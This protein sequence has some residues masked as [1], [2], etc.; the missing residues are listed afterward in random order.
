[1][2]PWIFAQ[3]VLPWEAVVFTQ[4]GGCVGD[5]QSWVQSSGPCSQA[6][7]ARSLA[8]LFSL[9]PR[10]AGWRAKHREESRGRGSGSVLWESEEE[11]T[12]PE[13]QPA[14][15]AHLNPHKP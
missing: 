15:E 5:E 3:P 11:Q 14:G 13:S 4:Q 6:S 8:G 12:L 9:R 10:A 1:M 2:D 7:G